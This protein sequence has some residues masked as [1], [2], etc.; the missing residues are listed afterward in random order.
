MALE[1]E[2]RYFDTIRDSLLGTHADHVAVIHGEQ[3]IGVYPSLEEA[4]SQAATKVGLVPMLIRK[5]GE[6]EQL[7]SIPAL[8]LGVLSANNPHPTNR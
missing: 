4:Y 7:V 8:A 2:K 6:Q 1:R 5:I 3:L